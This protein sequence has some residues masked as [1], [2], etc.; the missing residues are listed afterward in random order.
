MHIPKASQTYLFLDEVKKW[1]YINISLFFQKKKWKASYE[2]A[3]R[4]TFI[5]VSKA[6]KWNIAT[7]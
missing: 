5:H 4:C 6:K 2:S 3:P 1:M 7:I